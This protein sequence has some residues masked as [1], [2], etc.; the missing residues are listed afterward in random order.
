MHWTGPED[1]EGLVC[2]PWL[3]GAPPGIPCGFQESKI[4]CRVLCH[5]KHQRRTRA[6]PPSWRPFARLRPEQQSVTKCL[7]WGDGRPR[8][9]HCTITAARFSR[10]YSK[11]RTAV[12]FQLRT[13]YKTVL[14][15]HSLHSAVPPSTCLMNSFFFVNLTDTQR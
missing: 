9:Q 3:V 12:R 6:R 5:R 15:L 14:H 11:S 8:P 1:E 2:F 13:S 7:R 4:L 10:G